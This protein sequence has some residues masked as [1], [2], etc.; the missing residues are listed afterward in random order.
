MADEYKSLKL[1]EE[2][3]DFILAKHKPVI[4]LKATLE[5]STR[6]DNEVL[7]STSDKV[8]CSVFDSNYYT[9]IRTVSDISKTTSI[10]ISVKYP[11]T[12]NLMGLVTIIFQLNYFVLIIIA[13]LRQ[14]VECQLWLARVC[15]SSITLSGVSRH[16]HAGSNFWLFSFPYISKSELDRTGIYRYRDKLSLGRSEISQTS[17]ELVELVN[18]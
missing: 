11:K 9:D 2:S 14:G 4:C 10:S 5:N 7:R 8:L 12:P 1:P 13:R 17:K 6:F 16:V 3:G 15:R 18:I